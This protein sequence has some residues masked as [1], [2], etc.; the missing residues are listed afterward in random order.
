M[1]SRVIRCANHGGHCASGS[2]NDGNS[3]LGLAFDGKWINLAGPACH[4]DA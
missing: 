3:R 1:G 2:E 4:D